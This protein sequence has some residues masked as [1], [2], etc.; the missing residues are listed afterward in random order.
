MASTRLPFLLVKRI[1]HLKI[2]TIIP[3]PFKSH[4]V[5]DSF[6][7]WVLLIWLLFHFSINNKI[8]NGVLHL[9]IATE[10]RMHYIVIA[11]SKDKWNYTGN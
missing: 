3:V 2:K 5:G 6:M 11:A 1:Y 9:L 8:L 7:L 4:R 10:H